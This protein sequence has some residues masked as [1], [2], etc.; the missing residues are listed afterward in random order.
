MSTLREATRAYYAGDKQ[1][2]V[3]GLMSAA[4][5]GHPAAQWKLGRMFA[6]G[7]GVAED[8]LKA[9]EFF[10]QLVASHGTDAPSSPDAPFVANAFVEIGSYYLKGISNSAVTP[11]VDRAREIFSY[12]ASYFGDAVAQLQLGKMYL[13]GLGG[14]Q[15][16]RQAARWFQLAARKGQVDAQYHLGQMLVNGDQIDPNPVLGLMWLTVA[17]KHAD[18]SRGDEAAIRQ[19]HEEA[20]SL[21]SLDERRKAIALAEQWLA[22]NRALY[23]SPN[24]NMLAV[25]EQASAVGQ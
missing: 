23:A 21:A 8:D 14:D 19:A 15:D 17:L 18:L 6:S 16:P 22:D 7:D 5:S 3:S 4:Q 12:A 9:F 25:T 24:A 10:N 13:E 1:E 20:F 2:A 11:N